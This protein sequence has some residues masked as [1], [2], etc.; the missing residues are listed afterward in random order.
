VTALR[1]IAEGIVLVAMIVVIIAALSL[2][3]VR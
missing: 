1:T 2:V 3:D